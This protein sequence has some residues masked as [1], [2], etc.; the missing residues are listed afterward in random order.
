MRMMKETKK[1]RSLADELAY[2]LMGV[3]VG[4]FICYLLIPPQ[5]RSLIVFVIY[6][7][8]IISIAILAKAI[9]YIRK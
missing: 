4:L 1:K 6:E 5:A 3:G 9:T 2:T 8:I 7:V